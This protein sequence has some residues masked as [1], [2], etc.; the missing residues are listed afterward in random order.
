MGRSQHP[1]PTC[2][3]RGP[4]CVHTWRVS[5]WRWRGSGV[6]NAGPRNNRGSTGKDLG[7]V[8]TWKM[9]QRSDLHTTLLPSCTPV[10]SEWYTGL[11]AIRGQ[12]NFG[13][14][15]APS[16]QKCTSICST[17]STLS[18]GNLS[19]MHH[20]TA[21]TSWELGKVGIPPYTQEIT[22]LVMG[23]ISGEAH[24]ASRKEWE[25][26]GKESRQSPQ[27]GCRTVGPRPDQV[28]RSQCHT[29]WDYILLYKHSFKESLDSWGNCK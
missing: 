20:G 24:P 8:E 16:L 21:Q 18:P 2:W 4:H 29:S 22:L 7:R 10:I 12:Q 1:S 14:R 25:E 26:G 9:N 6:F 17:V 3:Q 27:R 15:I 11:S 13:E 5:G 23:N 19:P 28:S